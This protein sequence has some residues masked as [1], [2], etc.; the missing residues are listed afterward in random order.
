MQLQKSML[1]TKNVFIARGAKEVNI[2][3]LYSYLV[4]LKVKKSYAF[5]KYQFRKSIFQ[6]FGRVM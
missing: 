6:I 5:L 1:D 4:K 2:F 3:K